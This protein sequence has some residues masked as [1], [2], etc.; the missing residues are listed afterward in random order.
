VNASDANGI[1]G[2]A[3]AVAAFLAATAVRDLVDP[4]PAVTNDAPAQFPVGTT[5]VTFTARDASGN[6][7]RKSATLT[8]V[9]PA[10]PPVPSPSPLPVPPPTP[11]PTPLPPAP[12]PVPLDPGGFAAR[13]GRGQ[14]ALRWVTPSFSGFDH[15]ELLRAAASAGVQQSMVYRGK[16]S[17]FVD[18]KVKESELYRYQLV[19]VAA[20][21]DRS[22]GAALTA[23]AQPL[24]LLGPLD[25]A[26]LHA[27]PK[28]RWLATHGAAYY[29]LQLY[30]N[31]VKVLSTWPT[32]SA[33]VLPKS[34]KY[35][36]RRHRLAAGTYVWYVWPGFGSRAARKYGALLGHS[37]FN[38]SP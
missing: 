3:A 29:N 8:V 13:S 26:R 30:R 33:Y 6:A 20:D 27:P 14:I 23:F 15:V 34:W 12:K 22:P 2:S 25:G 38:V 5:T 4:A 1:A 21:G 24:R 7:T 31:G 36:G 17:S 37:S 9:A 19:A 35:L 11:N 16:G 18:K 28:L 10:A 32:R